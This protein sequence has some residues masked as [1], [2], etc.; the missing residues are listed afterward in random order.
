MESCT[1]PLQAYTATSNPIFTA[2]QKE[3]LSL[4]FYTSVG[5]DIGLLFIH[6]CI[7]LLKEGASVLFSINDLGMELAALSIDFWKLI[8][9]ALYIS[10]SVPVA[11]G[12]QHTLVAAC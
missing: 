11:T 6:N 10:S 7:L 8:N 9:A 2:T 5:H 12:V 3:I 1:G 4:Q